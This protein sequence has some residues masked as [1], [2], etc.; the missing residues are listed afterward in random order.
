LEGHDDDEEE[1]EGMLPAKGEKL[2][3][4]YITATERYSR[5][6]ARYTEA[7][8]VKKLEEL[9]IGRPSTMRLLFQLFSTEIML[10][11]EI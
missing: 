3:Q 7:S 8:L 1:Q 11:K 6:P 5:P 2:Q 9:G 4:H 10:R